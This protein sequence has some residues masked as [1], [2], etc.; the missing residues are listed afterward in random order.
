MMKREDA[1]K[2]TMEVIAKRE[3]EKADKAKAFVDN[4]VSKVIEDYAKCGKF[5]CVIFI[6]SHL[7]R[8][9][10]VEMIKENGFGV[11]GEFAYA[12]FEISWD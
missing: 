2:M 6:P 8:T 1:K 4:E 10:V 3:K 12:E 5:E 7:D 9:Q 11:K